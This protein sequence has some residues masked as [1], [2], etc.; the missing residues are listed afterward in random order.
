M[1]W[2][3]GTLAVTSCAFA[4][5]CGG[6]VSSEGKVWRLVGFEPWKETRPEGIQEAE[7]ALRAIPSKA[8]VM[9]RF[10]WGKIEH[11]DY[12]ESHLVLVTTLTAA[13]E[14]IASFLRSGNQ[15]T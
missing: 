9:E 4:L 1:K 6:E 15:R 2:L 14:A 11:G 12:P 3:V 5:G 7:D 13:T 8:P 10:E